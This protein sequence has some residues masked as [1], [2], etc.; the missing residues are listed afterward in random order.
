MP[1]NRLWWAHLNPRSARYATW[2]E[3]LGSDDVPLKKPSAV[4]CD[5]GHPVAETV[6][7]YELDLAVMT[8]EQ[9]GRLVDWCAAKFGASAA[10]IRAEIERSGYPIREADVMVAFS[11]RAFM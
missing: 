8:E 5:L 9:K 4:R 10:E 7:C 3:I 2:R 1:A 6:D 11:M